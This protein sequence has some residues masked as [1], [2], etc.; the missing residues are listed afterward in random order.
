MQTEEKLKRITAI[1]E[2]MKAEDVIKID[3]AEKTILADCFVL[4]TATSNTHARA[5]TDQLHVRMKAQGAAADRTETDTSREWTI[6]DFGDVVVHVFL[7]RARRYYNLEELWG[8][9]ESARR[10]HDPGPAAIPPGR[11]PAFGPGRPA[12]RSG[13]VARRPAGSRFRRRP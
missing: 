8:V 3:T 4:V 7:E 11:R 2:E 5:I 13:R 10:K 9:V 6:M 1:L 12:A